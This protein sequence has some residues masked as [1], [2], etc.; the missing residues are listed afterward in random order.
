[1]HTYIVYLIVYLCNISLLVLNLRDRKFIW[2][3]CFLGHP[4]L[5]EKKQTLFSLIVLV[6]LSCFY[7]INLSTSYILC[8]SRKNQYNDV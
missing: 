7:V 6:L 2:P 8:T 5:S 1:M 3:G 4:F